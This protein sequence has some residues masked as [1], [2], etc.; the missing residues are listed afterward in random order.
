MF[1][2]DEIQAVYG[3]IGDEGFRALVE[4]FYRRV[5]ND[6]L[7]RQIFPADLAEGRERQYLF[8]RQ[9]FGG[10][11]E[12]SARYG[13]PQL[14]RRHLPFAITRAARDVWLGHMLAAIDEVAIPEPHA[15]LMRRYFERFS[16]DMINRDDAGAV[17]PLT[18]GPAM[19]G[20]LG[21]NHQGDRIE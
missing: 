2:I 9:Y 10:P 15:S 12:Y 18:A 13:H 3:A 7:L 16:L 1:P 5:E 8:L 11:A 6:P 21:R 20:V 14:R 17:A 4:A 19:I